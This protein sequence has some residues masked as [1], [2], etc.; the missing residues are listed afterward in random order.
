MACMSY[1]YSSSKLD[2]LSKVKSPVCQS[3]PMRLDI[4]LQHQHPASI[5]RAELGGLG[6]TRLLTDNG[7][8]CMLTFGHG[9]K[10]AIVPPS[11]LKPSCHR[12]ILFPI[13]S[14]QATIRLS[15]AAPFAEEVYLEGLL[16]S[17]TSPGTS[18][19]PSTK[20]DPTTPRNKVQRR[21]K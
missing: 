2:I 14:I 16:L 11:M 17:S 1:N 15:F 5:P 8:A 10:Y 19:W 4:F 20:R 21:S 7:R 12:S 6:W 18:P 9:D 13:S 3:Q